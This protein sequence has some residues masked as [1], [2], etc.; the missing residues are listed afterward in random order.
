MKLSGLTLAGLLGLLVL[1]EQTARADG[2]W[3]FNSSSSSSTSKSNSASRP[4]AKHQTT[5]PSTWDTITGAPKKAY[6]A[7]KDALT[8]KKAPPTR[9]VGNYNPY[10]RKEPEKKGWF[11]SMFGKKEPEPPKSLKEWM[12]L[13]R[14][15]P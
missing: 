6:T 7:T 13:P 11:D 12:S 15:D 4:A 5:A 10:M 1:V 3:P 9:P 2:W 8:P 14:A